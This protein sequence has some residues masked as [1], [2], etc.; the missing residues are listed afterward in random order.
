M[1]GGG[2]L[3]SAK[4]YAKIGNNIELF[5]Y[6][7]NYM[8]GAKTVFYNSIRITSMHDGFKPKK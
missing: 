5:V 2:D 3:Q 1:Q 7:P 8:G 6:A 4:E